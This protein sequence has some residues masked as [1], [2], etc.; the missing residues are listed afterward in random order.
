MLIPIAF[1]LVLSSVGKA[2]CW[3]VEPRRRGYLYNLVYFW[4]LAGLLWCPAAGGLSADYF[5]R[6]SRDI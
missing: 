6:V 1:V 2:I 3:T 5:A 4:K